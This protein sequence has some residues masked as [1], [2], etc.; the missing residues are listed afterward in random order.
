MVDLQ[1]NNLL[2]T[3]EKYRVHMDKHHNNDAGFS[4][5]IILDMVIIESRACER[6]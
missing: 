4:N 6:T 2:E 3:S 1:I 5:I